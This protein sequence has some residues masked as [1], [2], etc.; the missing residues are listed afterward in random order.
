MEPAM[1]DVVGPVMIGPSSSHTAGADRIALITRNMCP[2]KD[3]KHIKF[4]LY[5]SF[6]E[7]HKGHGTDKALLGGIMG[8]KAD[9]TRIKN[10][11]ELIKKE[12]FDYKIIEDKSPNDYH[13]NTVKIEIEGTT[14]DKFMTIGQSIGGGR[15]EIIKIN[16]FDV[17]ISGDLNTLLIEQEDKPGVL[18][19]IAKI[20]E[21][22]NIN[23]AFTTLYREAKGEKA[24]TVVETDDNITPE[25]VEAVERH[26]YVVTA[27]AFDV[28][29]K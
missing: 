20:L 25:I 6:A 17:T 23:I 1:F 14:G 19:H 21:V 13:P 29:M 28:D 12:K 9:D 24:F 5:N 18:A 10:S 27:I 22:Y 15:M 26:P 8:F 4:T 16:D 7:T 3:F 2:F 11:D